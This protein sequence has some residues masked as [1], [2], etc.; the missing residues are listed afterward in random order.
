MFPSKSFPMFE[1]NIYQI[2]NLNYYKK[3]QEWWTD[4]VYGECNSLNL[5]RN[6]ESSKN[7]LK[8]WKVDYK[9]EEYCQVYQHCFYLGELTQFEWSISKKTK[10]RKSL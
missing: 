8:R 2:L 1:L 5:Y 10:K 4:G 3:L 9:K 7:L 6:T